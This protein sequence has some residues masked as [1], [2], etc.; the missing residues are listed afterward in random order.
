MPEDLMIPD[1]FEALSVHRDPAIVLAE[2]KKAA[3][4]LMTVI[5]AKKKKVVFNGETYL[6]NEDWLT[7]ARFYGVTARI[8]STSYIEY[9]DVHGY[10]A[11]AEAY[12]MT[13]G[14]IVS[15][16]ESMC[17]NDELNWSKKP[18]FQLRS[19]AQTRASSRVLRQVFGW[20]VV[21][22]GFRPTPAEELDDQSAPV[23]QPGKKTAPAPTG[24]VPCSECKAVN[25]HLPFCSHRQKQEEPK[26]VLVN[27]EAVD[28]RHKVERDKKGR[29]YTRNFRVLTSMNVAN[30][31]VIL[32]AYDTKLFER[33][34]AIK[35]DTRC[36]F[37]I[38][39]QMV[40]ERTYYA[41]ESILE[42]TG[43]KPQQGEL[44]AT[45]AAKAEEDF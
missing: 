17:L 41:I 29:E 27:V 13:G 7:V 45:P 44:L 37:R 22:E 10:E 25:G 42:I 39:S 15:V 23:R 11:T 12:S 6:E 18:L 34:D 32:Y 20:V 4:A 14:E 31:Q 21:L 19:M 8:R 24:D 1:K 5:K 43:E 2:A 36:R 35:P 9:G 26:E 28:A 30:E 38:H 3:Q 40:N 33:L 16:A